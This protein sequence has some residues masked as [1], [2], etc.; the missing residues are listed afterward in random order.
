MDEMS[1]FRITIIN[2]HEVKDLN[3]CCYG[4]CVVVHALGK[5]I[6]QADLFS[7]SGHTHPEKIV[8]VM[9]TSSN[10]NIVRVTGP[11]CGEFTGPGEFPA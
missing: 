4:H 6:Q 11:L 10:G 9:S 1:Q 3:V 2:Y 7:L 5:D 8:F